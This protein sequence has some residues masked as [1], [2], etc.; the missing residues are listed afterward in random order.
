[1]IERLLE[2]TI[3]QNLYLFKGKVI[4]IMG[5]RQT[6][7]TTLLKQIFNKRKD[8]SW[9]NADEPDVIALFESGI[10]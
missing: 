5:A 1:M 9:F 3:R 6:G 8:I 2:K 10:L 7:K 4:V